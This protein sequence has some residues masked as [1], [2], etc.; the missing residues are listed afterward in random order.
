MATPPVLE[1]KNLAAGYRGRAVLDG[2]DF[3]IQPGELWVVLGR[4]GA[5]KSTL[6]R[7]CLG[8]LPLTGG[9]ALLQG[10]DVATLTRRAIA[11]QAAWVPQQ[12]DFGSEFTGLE[13][14]LMGR[15]P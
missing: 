15:F 8:L 7:A 2:I 12:G 5:G 6:L 14:V 13:L 3:H 11:Q 4:N 1:A 9:T 10:V